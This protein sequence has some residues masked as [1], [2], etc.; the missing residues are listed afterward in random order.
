V[1][2]SKKR[3]GTHY[4]EHVFLHPVGYLVHVVHSGASGAGNVEALFFWLGWDRYEYDKKCAGHVTPKLCF[5]I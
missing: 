4:A 3:T 5:S 1:Q 2:F